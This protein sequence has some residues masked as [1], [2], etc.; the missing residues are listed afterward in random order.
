MCVCTCGGCEEIVVFADA[1]SAVPLVRVLSFALW[2]QRGFCYCRGLV[3]YVAAVVNAMSG[4]CFSSVSV[5]MTTRSVAYAA[6]PPRAAMRAS[7]FN[8]PTVRCCFFCHS[9]SLS[10]TRSVSFIFADPHVRCLR[11]LDARSVSRN[12]VQ[13]GDPASVSL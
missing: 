1:H 2:L 12:S 11:S 4:T 9:L 5:Q 8:A 10:R 3:R 7:G 6:L 13:E